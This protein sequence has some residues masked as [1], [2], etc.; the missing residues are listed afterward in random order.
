VESIKKVQEE[1]QKQYPDLLR[2]AAEAMAEP[3]P[4][5]PQQ[6]PAVDVISRCASPLQWLRARVCVCVRVH[7]CICVSVCVFVCVCARALVCVCARFC[8]CVHACVRVC[9][10]VCVC[11]C[12]CACVRACVRVCAQAAMLSLLAVFPVALQ[13]RSKHPDQGVLLN[14]EVVVEMVLHGGGVI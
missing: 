14:Y 1:L 5:A 11:A 3:V 4:T 8:A 13:G 9:A 2:S 12:L 6:H 7:A 10:L